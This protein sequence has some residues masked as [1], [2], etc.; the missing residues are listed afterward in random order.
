[1]AIEFIFRKKNVFTRKFLLSTVAVTAMSFGAIF[2]MADNDDPHIQPKLAILI[3]NITGLSGG[4]LMHIIAYFLLSMAILIIS[5]NIFR[6]DGAVDLIVNESGVKSPMWSPDLI[7]WSDIDHV[8]IIYGAGKS[9]IVKFY[10]YP[11]FKNIHSKTRLSKILSVMT[12]YI[13]IVPAVYGISIDDL[14]MRIP[15]DKLYN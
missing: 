15:S 4:Q 9:I 12:N 14:V 7:P 8:K 13:S 3:E 11:E 2:G 1:M 10:F 6:K 5:I